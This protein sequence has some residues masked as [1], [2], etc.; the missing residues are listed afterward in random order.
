MGTT[1][2]VALALIVVAYYEEILLDGFHLQ[3]NL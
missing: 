1:M 3:Y 2:V